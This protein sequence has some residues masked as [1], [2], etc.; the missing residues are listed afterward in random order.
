MVG[1]VWIDESLN[2]MFSETRFIFMQFTGLTDKNG[3]EIYEGDIVTFIGWR[4]RVVTWQPEGCYAGWFAVDDKKPDRPLG[5]YSGEEPN[6]I[7]VLGNIYENPEL[8][9]P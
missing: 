8:L 3:K 9:K 5:I 2:Q 4:N 6:T 7:E 1:D